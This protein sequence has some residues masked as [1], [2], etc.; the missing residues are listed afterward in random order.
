MQGH[1]TPSFIT[2]LLD[3]PHEGHLVFIFIL[4]CMLST[5]FAFIFF[6]FHSLVEHPSAPSAEP[7]KSPS[8]ADAQKKKKKSKSRKVS[9]DSNKPLMSSNTSSEMHSVIN[10]SNHTESKHTESKCTESK[11]TESHA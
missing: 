11:N 1:I 3:K 5:L 4:S 8:S 6:S 9:G 2:V 7:S 10:E